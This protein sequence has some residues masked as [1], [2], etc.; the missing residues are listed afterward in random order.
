MKDI[1]TILAKDPRCEGRLGRVRTFRGEFDTPMFMPVGTKAS[2]KA[3]DPFDLKNLGAKI[4]L[5]NTYHLMLRP[6]EEL[7]RDLGGLHRFMGWDDPILTDSG[8][9]QIFSLK[10][11]TK[12]GEEGATFRSC[13]DGTSFSFSPERAIEVQNALGSDIMMCLDECLAYPAGR[14]EAEASAERTL[15]WAERSYEVWDENGPQILFGIA[16][17]GF[18]HDLREKSARDIGSVGFPGHAAGGLALG[19]PKEM[20]LEAIEASFEG[21]PPDKPRYLMGL[22]T[23]LDILDG[24]RLGA[25]MF[26]CVL[27]TRNARNG[28]FFTR[29][30]KLNIANARHGTADLP[31]EEG[32]GCHTCRN[33]SRAYLRHLF[34]QR[35]PLFMRLATIHNLHFYLT[36]VENART[37]LQNGDFLCYYS[38]FGDAYGR[39]ET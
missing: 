6:G 39:G 27:P 8:G 4:I 7:V 33:F 12:I 34:R 3:L 1:F 20:M 37:A 26:D 29:R 10:D 17:G 19:E 35:E 23:P 16:Q 25:D 11:S 22:G 38:E 28:Q 30:G 18:H 24:I 2:V 15:R 9:F 36:L 32:C 13:Y 5:S 31:P 14:S 21:L